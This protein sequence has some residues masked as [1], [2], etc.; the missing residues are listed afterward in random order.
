[1][2]AREEAAGDGFSR[3]LRKHPLNMFRQQRGPSPLPIKCHGDAAAVSGANRKLGSDVRYKVTL[4]TK[5]RALFVFNLET[6]YIP[7]N[8]RFTVLH[9]RS[10]LLEFLVD[11]ESLSSWTIF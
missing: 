9:P 1:M 4:Q 10:L 2:T 8:P 11:L 7:K 6:K 3:L 5:T